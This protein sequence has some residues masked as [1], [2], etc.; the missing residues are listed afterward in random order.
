VL[1]C[2]NLIGRLVRDPEFKTV[3]GSDLAL[4]T[5][6]NDDSYKKDGEKVD[7]VNFIPVQI[8]GKSTKF[9]KDYIVKGM[10]VCVKGKLETK[11]VEKEGKKTTYFCIKAD[12]FGGIEILQKKEQPATNAKAEVVE[13][14]DFHQQGSVPF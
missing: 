13:D 7:K 11:T 2:I 1:N 9:V 3:G 4:I 5:I 6:A 14:N 12:M 8:W 10:L